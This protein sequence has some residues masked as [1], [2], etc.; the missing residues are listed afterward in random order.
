MGYSTAGSARPSGQYL[1]GDLIG[2]VVSASGIA[3]CAERKAM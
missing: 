3:E 2:A 1:C